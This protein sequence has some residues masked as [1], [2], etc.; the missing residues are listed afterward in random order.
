MLSFTSVTQFTKKKGDS[1]SSSL[2]PPPPPSSSTQY[3][4]SQNDLTK[5]DIL[6]RSL[7]HILAISNDT[8]NLS[9][10]LKFIAKS[11][12][13]HFL[14][15][16][17]VE[18]HWN[19]FHYALY[20]Y[21]FTFVKILLNFQSPVL[22][23]LLK[24]KDKN[25]L[26]P[27][28]LLQTFKS[29][30]DISPRKIYSTHCDGT[31]NFKM[32]LEPSK[33]IPSSSSLIISL[34]SGDY[35]EINLQENLFPPVSVNPLISPKIEK[36]VSCSTHSALITL[37]GH[38]YLSNPQ[39]TLF[40]SS[41]C[42]VQFFDDLWEN[43]EKVVDLTLTPGHTI[44]LTSLD[45]AFAF[46]NNIKRLNL[47]QQSLP[48][49]ASS[50]SSSLSFSSSPTTSYSKDFNSLIPLS[51]S[52]KGR[53][54]SSTPSTSSSS[55]T[56]F[57]A[58][59]FSALS[60]GSFNISD[61]ISSNTNKLL[62]V[63]AS[64]NHTIIYSKSALHIH[65]LNLGQ[66]GPLIN[67]TFDSP[68][69]STSSSSSSVHFNWKYDEDPIYQVM[70]LDLAT[71][72]ITKSSL[73]HIYVS[74]LH[75]KLSLPLNKDLK[76][77]WNK[78]KP[79]IL[80]VPKKIVKIVSPTSND[81]L[82]STKSVDLHSNYSLL[83]LLNSGEVY[84]FNFPKY[85]PSKEVFKDS[86]KFTLIWNP[87]RLEM[88]AHDISIGPIE[89]NNN[90]GIG[91]VLCTKSGEAF[92]RTKTKW[93]RINDVSKITNVS[94]GFGFPV[95]G[96]FNYSDDNPFK[97]IL[98]RQEDCLLKHEIGESDAL[99]D[100]AKLS[101]IYHFV[102]RQ[103]CYSKN[104]NDMDYLLDIDSLNRNHIHYD[105][106]A[107]ENFTDTIKDIAFES[108][109]SPPQF[110]STTAYELLSFL[111][112][113][114]LESDFEEH[115][116][117]ISNKI[118]RFYDY[119]I[120]VKDTISKLEV[121]YRAHKNFIFTRMKITGST[122]SIERKN[123]SLQFN[124]SYA[125][126]IGDIDVRGV[127][128]FLHMLYT[129]EIHSLITTKDGDRIK[130]TRDRLILCYRIDP[131]LTTM[132]EFFTSG[133]SG[134]VTI[135]LADG[136]FKTWKFFL[137]CRCDYFKQYFSGH[138]QQQ[139]ILD[140]THISKSTWELVMKYLA[141]YYAN[142]LFFETINELVD[143]NIRNISE[144][145]LVKKKASVFMS[146]DISE[147]ILNSS[148]DFVNI[149]LELLYFS[150]ELLLSNLRQICELA[151]KDLINFSNYDILL[152]H[153]FLSKSSQLFSDCAWFIFNNLFLCY[154]DQRLNPNV[155]GDHCAALL[156]NKFH[157]I[158]RIYIPNRD[159]S[160]GKIDHNSNIFI[161]NVDEFNKYYLH[162]LL[163]DE[164]GILEIDES[165]LN[166]P[167]TRRKSQTMAKITKSNSAI[168]QQHEILSNLTSRSSSNESAISDD[169]DYDQSDGFVVVQKGRRKSS[170][171]STL[172]SSS[173]NGR[174]YSST[175]LNKP[176]IESRRDSNGTVTLNSNKPINEPWKIVRKVSI[177]SEIP[178]ESTKNI[179]SSLDDIFSQPKT[180]SKVDLKMKSKITAPMRISQKERKQR[181]RDATERAEKDNKGKGI[182]NGK[183]PW[184]PATVWGM[185][186]PRVVDEGNI[187]GALL[188]GSSSNINL[189]K[190][191]SSSSI[192]YAELNT[193]TLLAP[194]KM[195]TVN[196]PS[197]EEIKKS[198]KLSK[199]KNNI[200][201]EGLFSAPAIISSSLSSSS[202]N[203]STNNLD[204]LKSFEEIKA[205]E[206]FEKW[207][208]EESERVQRSMKATE[209]TTNANGFRNDNQ[210]IARGNGIGNHRG[211]GNSNN[212][213][214]NNNNNRGG[215][216][217]HRGS[218][219]RGGGSIG[220]NK[221]RGKSGDGSRGGRKDKGK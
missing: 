99:I 23:K 3:S 140:F 123:L 217:G 143:N 5:R 209:G 102:Q 7:L 4:F 68:T 63:T 77:S 110:K 2:Q 10:L 15:I 122:H 62:G 85:S 111:S 69:S 103:P 6:G 43:N 27:F 219:N 129:D 201:D 197:L 214:N 133:E 89:S 55:S 154:N 190:Q 165:L 79:R 95:I 32:E 170:S 46:G 70:A 173:A 92:K 146:K 42:R 124:D 11:N 120:R 162:Q 47:Y 189:P 149:V 74:G 203:N 166:I 14:L 75:I 150:N 56:P 172:I 96:N 169:T 184:V 136:E 105:H 98:L 220:G 168:L 161:N 178:I 16:Q 20:Y 90:T 208:K 131:I 147:N 180:N 48:T 171:T 118:N 84:V 8:S 187:N 109:S 186:A 31:Y 152:Q 86:V 141:G 82:D 160:S 45:R 9:R 107:F 142:D 192:V 93:T 164:H 39:T 139:Q 212:N 37:S 35:T 175:L 121:T 100:F 119:E 41:F 155:I 198:N 91:A 159:N 125:T 54:S 50:S 101:P 94:I 145:K 156:D 213:N 144:K 12:N 114:E 188:T 191:G 108:Y 182:D 97:T 207:W 193:A 116:S 138:W 18:N 78:F 28:D 179:S 17:D 185:N 81:R 25:N 29:T 106:N 127:A 215:R 67:A 158:I 51:V 53:Y 174:S 194:N 211:R 218:S 33:N 52:I 153:A 130:E 181:E 83:T 64:N 57:F 163:W 112:E 205:E 26:A 88:R 36:F 126:I 148:D 117:K 113:S 22:T 196:F 157:E 38:L 87:S 216:G 72:V 167:M 19:V 204:I 40:N 21:N 73:I 34:S 1:F 200:L 195:N 30:F 132:K 66:F 210:I 134:D 60:G 115:Q 24:Q 177:N 49:S 137:S 59:N 206:E 58:N 183:T 202:F 71:L 135:N 65:G 13:H 76:D 128:L 199:V 80:S 151:I 44:V 104:F 176:M 61:E 221:G